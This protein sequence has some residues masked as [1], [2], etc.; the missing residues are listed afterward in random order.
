MEFTIEEP[1]DEEPKIKLKFKHDGDKG[2]LLQG[3]D[4][5]GNSRLIMG[6]DNGKF[7]RF[8]GADLEGLEIGED[9]RIIEDK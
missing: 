6:F 5:N 8:S 9:E 4:K 3:I 2:L 1:K 7:Y